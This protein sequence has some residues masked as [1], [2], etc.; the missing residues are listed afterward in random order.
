[1]KV[2][3]SYASK[4]RAL[5]EDLTKRLES[6]GI[7]VFFDRDD[8]LPGDA[9]DLQITQSLS[10]S[11]L[12][13]FL[14]SPDSLRA[15]AYTQT[16]LAMA[17]KQ[18]PKAT[19][20]VI[21]LLVGDTAITDLPSYLRSVSVLKPEGDAIAET[22]AAVLRLADRAH[23]RLRWLLLGGGVL[24]ALAAAAFWKLAPQSDAPYRIGNVA[25]AKVAAGYRFTANLKNGGPEPVTTVNLYAQADNPAVHFS[26]DFE[27]FELLP[28]DEKAAS[29]DLQL[30][31]GAG[32]KPFKWR[33][34]WV[35]VKSLDL[36]MA[37]DINPIEKFIDQ[38]SRTVCTAYRPWA[39]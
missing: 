1:M 28:T 38:R 16:E 10:H 31:D 39:P 23:R 37:K 22:V 5:A 34:C 19:G 15:G 12:L 21:T 20:R 30:A 17:E 25:V 14:A 36:E 6:A 29:V 11:D 18:W 26:G 2:F 13:V 24:L 8:L 27:W 9:F 35:V 4:Q 7:D 33:L 32:G 3:L